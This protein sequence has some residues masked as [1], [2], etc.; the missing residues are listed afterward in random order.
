MFFRKNVYQKIDGIASKIEI[1]PS[2]FLSIP[3]IGCKIAEKTLELHISGPTTLDFAEAQ[4]LTKKLSRDY[5]LDIRLPR[6]L[7]G[8]I[9]SQKLGLNHQYEWRSEL[10]DGSFLMIN[11]TARSVNNPRRYDF[12]SDKVSLISNSRNEPKN[13][14]NLCWLGISKDEYDRAAVV[15]SY[16]NGKCSICAVPPLSK[17]YLGIRLLIDEK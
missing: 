5:N 10:I 2:N 7:E 16:D 11:P 8:Y 12:Y 13:K 4:L 14:G 15:S 9:A 1:E 17:D 3:E 6:T